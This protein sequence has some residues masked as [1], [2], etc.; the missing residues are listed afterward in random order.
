M[1]IVGLNESPDGK[2]GFGYAYLVI[3]CPDDRFEGEMRLRPKGN[4]TEK[5]VRLHCRLWVL[6]YV[7]SL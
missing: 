4:A 6:V 3:S 1:T 2:G 5:G 7:T